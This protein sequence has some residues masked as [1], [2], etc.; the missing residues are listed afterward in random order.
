M[1]RWLRL[2]L[3]AALA[4]VIVTAVVRL[5][6]RA[7]L[8][9]R[10]QFSTAVYDRNGVLL[11]LTLAHDGRYRLRT[12]L[13]TVPPALI[14]AVLQK[15]DQWY[16][17]H[18]G[19][20][21]AALVRGAWRSYVMHGRR[22]GGSTITMQLARLMYHLDTR[23][24][25]GKLRQIERALLLELK[26][27]KHDLLETYLNLLPY[28]RNIEGVGAAGLVYF[29]KRVGA[30]TV[31][32]IYALAV[33]PQLPGRRARVRGGASSASLLRARQALF[34][35][36]L[37]KHAELA[38]FA[39]LMALPLSLRAP[40]ELPFRAPH[41]VDQLLSPGHRPRDPVTTVDS[42]LQTLLERQIH[43]YIG[44][45]SHLGVRNAVAL[46]ADVRNMEVLAL[47]GS[48]DFHNAQIHGQ[49][50]GALGPRS[51]GSTLKPFI[52]ALA[53]DQGLIHPQTMLKDGPLNFRDYSPE[54]FDG[55]FLGPVSA[56]DALIRSRNVP[57][58][59]LAARLQ[60]P[61]LYGLL[62]AGGVQRLASEQHYG[63][64]LVLGGG[65]VTM[66]EL[67]RL[68]GAL[69]NGGLLQPLRFELAVP[70]A[71]ARP[72]VA[73]FS[74]EAAFL[75]LDILKDNPRPDRNVE[76]G[77][78]RAPVAWKTGTSWGFR[79]AWTVG[80]FGHYVLAVWLG[81][82]DGSGNPALVGVQ[83]AAPLFFSIADAIGALRGLDSPPWSVPPAGVTR[84]EVCT[85]TG[86]LPN[87]WCPQRTATWFIPGRSP[88]ALSTVHRPVTIDI[89]TGKVA[90]KEVAASYRR[91]EV[92]EFW[93]SETMRLFREAGVPRRAPPLVDAR[94]AGEAGLTEG[95]A[96][97]ILSPASHQVY[98][99]R[100]RRKGRESVSL[101]ASVDADV[102]V[103]Y[104]FANQALLGSSAAGEP[105][106]W[107]PEVAGS[108]LLRAVDDHGRTDERQVAVAIA[109]E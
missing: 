85:A 61:N 69:G 83:Q 24:P 16:W 32:E 102:K 48:A 76:S 66:E 21:P 62:Q 41:L 98:A 43:S 15:E 109:E 25:V 96:P 68:Y 19:F 80:L 91:T 105:L 77:D 28:G 49:V 79:D 47:V 74:P 100:R 5:W 10:F 64:A 56:S 4:P 18:P 99:L 59:S 35:R 26:F 22:E 6:P 88:I 54:N 34:A 71:E 65:E 87:A 106:T 58:I 70:A 82:F 57:A 13:Q 14:D 92:Y 78:T 73:L 55:R 90:C 67:V 46:L 31:P 39:P 104:W 20:N 2:A 94:C 45:Q 23:T 30:L 51:P 81:N 40:E 89:R 95:T 27:S 84:V 60:S 3:C 36:A 72:N 93:P 53:L 52:Y 8:A 50:N 42:E 11:R 33:I 75:V 86:Q 44:R 12:P 7:A 103:L 38:R 9:A 17:V 107:N 37:P 63:L 29:D 108:F 1:S 97:K 101:S